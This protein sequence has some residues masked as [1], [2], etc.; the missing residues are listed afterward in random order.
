MAFTSSSI[1]PTATV[2]TTKKSH[3]LIEPS[4]N[5]NTVVHTSKYSR[6]F[7][8][9]TANVNTVVHTSKNA[10][11][12]IKPSTN[13]TTVVNPTTNAQTT[14]MKKHAMHKKPPRKPSVKT[15]D[16]VRSIVEPIVKVK[17]VRRS[18]R[19]IWKGHAIKNGLGKDMDNPIEVVDEEVA[20]A[21]GKG[22]M[23]VKLAQGD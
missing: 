14:V 6:T 5:I 17:H 13:V 3:T 1:K 15:I 11:T 16:V 8:K 2:H 18:G 20:E 7:V 4:T 9:P 10:H 21:T 23:V 19:T 22:K 12:V